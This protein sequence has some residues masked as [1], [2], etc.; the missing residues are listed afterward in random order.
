MDYI[1]NEISSSEF[2]FPSRL[3]KDDRLILNYVECPIP[4]K[5]C[6]GKYLVEVFGAGS[7]GL[8]GYARGILN[9]IETSTFYAYIGGKGSRGTTWNGGGVGYNTT[10]YGES[11][12]DL[13]LINGD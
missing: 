12:T 6:S 5:L 7:S 13:R 9:L 2:S 3:N 8:G 10:H 1:V 4:V 11:A